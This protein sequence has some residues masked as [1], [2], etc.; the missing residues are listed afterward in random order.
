MIA[1]AETYKQEELIFDVQKNK[2]IS[3]QEVIKIYLKGDGLKMV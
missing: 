1:N 3:T 2:K